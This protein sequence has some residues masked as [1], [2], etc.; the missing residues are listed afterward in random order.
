VTGGDETQQADEGDASGANA[1]AGTASTAATAPDGS[2]VP[3]SEADVIAWL[4]EHPEFLARNPDLLARLAPPS[5]AEGESVVDL[6]AWM[7][8]RLQGNLR[9]LN[10]T[11]GELIAA[12]RTNMATQ[13]Q[14]H[15]AVV[16]LAG[17]TDIQHFVHILTQDLREV[18]NVD[19]IALCVESWTEPVPDVADLRI[20]P[21]GAIGHIMGAGRRIRLR[22]DPRD[23]VAIYGPAA[24][25]VR[26]DALIPIELPEDDHPA[27]IAIGS[28][29]EEHFHPGQ[30]TELLTFLAEVVER[31]LATWL[32]T[33]S[34]R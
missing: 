5:R 21:G 18:I 17:A 13:S 12:T 27:L 20:L 16:A 4:T 33:D 32:K 25:L 1:T 29:Q 11:Q 3:V 8:E 28:R 6:Q 26:S 15:R 14:V 2:G 24:G 31:T 10:S 7:I 19:V 34:G 22:T 30:G 23:K 9:D